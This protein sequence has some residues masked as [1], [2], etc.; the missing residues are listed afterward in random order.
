VRPL[1]IDPLLPEIVRTLRDSPVLV[2]EAEPGA[3]KTT[4]VPA[5]LLDGG[6]ADAGPIWVA[7]P[8][9]LA[10]RLAA[11]FVARERGEPV[12]RTVGYAVR[13]E[14]VASAETRIL[15]ATEA[16]LLNRLAAESDS[17]APA[18]VVLDEFHERHLSTDLLFVL[19]DRLRRTSRPDLRLVVMS[20]TLEAERLAAHLNAPRLK[21]EGRSFPLSIEHVEKPDDR[22]LEK[23][24]ASAVRR[25]LKEEASGDILVFLPGAR[26]IRLAEGALAPE[27]DSG[28]VA[29][30]PLHGDLSA[31][32]QA[33][34]IE[35]ATK[36]KVILSTNVA[37]SSVTIDGV[38]A[39]VDS[40]LARVAGH[41]PWSGL[42]TLSTAKISRAS[43]TQRAG[44]AGRTRAGRV[45]RLYGSTDLANRPEQ[46]RPEI[47]REDLAEAA[48]ILAASGVTDPSELRFLDPPPAPAMEAAKTLLGRLS[49]IGVDGAITDTGRRLLS[50]SLPPRLARVIVEGERR[51]VA[52]E[53][54]LA[55]A[56]LSER[57]I[58]KAGRADFGPGRGRQTV[59][60]SGP[61][62]V[63]ELLERFREA[64]DA[65][66]DARRLGAM[67][68]DHRTV[69]TVDR[70][71]KKLAAGARDHGHAP[72]TL[73]AVD[74][75]IQMALLTGFPDRLA[76]RRASG[77]AALVLFSGKTARLS[78][79]SVVRDARLMVTLDAEEVNGKVVVRLASAVDAEW[80]F[81]AYPD[82][83][84]MS[85]DLEWNSTSEVVE[86]VSRIR[87]GSVLLEEDRRPAP[88]S[89][90]A[91]R[92]L[93]Q[94]LRK[95]GVG[96]LARDERAG[97]VFRRLQLLREYLPEAGLP[98]VSGDAMDLA[99]EYASAGKTRRSEL[100][101]MD[102][103]EALLGGLTHEQRGLLDREA[104]ERITL[105]G[106]RGVTVNYEAGKPPWVE[107]RLQDFFGMVKT[108]TLA[109]GRVP[110]TI[111]LLAPN[112]RA[113]QVTTDLAGFWERHYPALRRELGRRYP[114]HPWP[115]DG[116]SAT[117]P[118]PMPPRRRPS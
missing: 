101:D 78:E 108:P 12:G 73:D 109:R 77:D 83:V 86:L 94:S 106:G 38:T 29:I 35:P 74:R 99:L 71:Q 26:E 64:E 61:S 95:A 65:G 41:S 16:L 27:A 7:E 69:K 67:N 55:A 88:P 43:A 30:L 15:Y 34:A 14:R 42:P 17:R 92:L 112:Q 37:E 75:A 115:E 22:P 52:R 39:V 91:S 28:Q 53:T 87:A 76:R 103:G 72:A 58:R 10:A 20:A 56:L 50:F 11:E 2:L 118:P 96:D 59:D 84:E 19:V 70:T 113:V 80:I 40:G 33:R 98:E 90:A 63:L 32:E 104:P 23:Q 105:P 68:L 79:N 9:R 102:L 1:P 21:S 81:E 107:S 31:A 116:K 13:F 93:A 114:R 4:R 25:L 54:C 46:D 49:A 62:D 6:F 45:L 48:L 82:L 89:E 66:F 110:L 97:L 51:G 5:A 85:D 44:R 18:V 36:R 111:H 47:L 100:A 8:R 60:A 117:P 3:G 57:D 24:V